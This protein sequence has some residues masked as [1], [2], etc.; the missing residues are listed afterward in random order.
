[1]EA[2]PEP[3]STAPTPGRDVDLVEQWAADVWVDVGRSIDPKLV[4][5]AD[6]SGLA[7]AL[8]RASRAGYDVQQHLPCLA[9][10]SPLPDVRPARALHYR[11]V[12][13]CAAAITP[14]P[15]RLRN[16]DDQQRSAAA[17]ARLKTEADLDDNQPAVA[18]DLTRPPVSGALHAA[19]DRM[20]TEGRRLDNE[21]ARTAPAGRPAPAARGTTPPRLASTA[22]RPVG[23]TDRRG[24]QR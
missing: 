13:E 19:Q 18:P 15:Q 5:G 21:Q 6:W 8:D 16:V 3:G 14:M 17:L 12:D 2:K 11:L 9:A 20:R 4:A 24:P 10:R 1:M 23:P 7:A 22:D